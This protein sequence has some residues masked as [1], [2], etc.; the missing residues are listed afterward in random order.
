MHLSMPTKR[1]PTR[2]VATQSPACLLDLRERDARFD[3]TSCSWHDF[4]NIPDAVLIRV[5]TDFTFACH[6]R[7]VADS[8]QDMDRDS[9]SGTHLCQMT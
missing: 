8:V 4:S 2:K 6:G 3:I 5:Q 9:E 1:G 7:S